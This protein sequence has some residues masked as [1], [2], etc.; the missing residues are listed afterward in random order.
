MDKTV[1]AAVAD[2]IDMY[3]KEAKSEFIVIFLSHYNITSLIINLPNRGI[4]RKEANID[5]TTT[6]LFCIRFL[7][8]C[9]L[10]IA[11]NSTAQKRAHTQVRPYRIFKTS[12]TI[13]S[14]VNP[15]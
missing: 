15:R 5:T 4:A 13:L 2:L 6:K 1:G 10:C 12:P 11:F 9:I 14:P 8:D 3:C 7:I